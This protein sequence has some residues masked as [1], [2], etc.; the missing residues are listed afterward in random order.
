MAAVV[1]MTEDGFLELGLRLHRN[2]LYS[3]GRKVKRETK[4]E[5][6]RS[7]YGPHPGVMAE[8]W[9]DLHTNPIKEDRVDGGMTATHLLI[10]YRFLKSYESE[11]DLHSHYGYGEKKIREWCRVIPEKVALLR[12]RK[13]CTPANKN[14]LEN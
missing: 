11:R 3:S 10:A 4:I 9:N 8:I 14:W 6:F 7:V 5:N 1:P 13:V 2:G 12:K